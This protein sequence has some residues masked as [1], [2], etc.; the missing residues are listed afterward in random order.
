MRIRELLAAKR[1]EILSAAARFGASNVRII[2]SV[3][4]NEDDE[5][6]DLDLLV[7]L[8][9][10]RSLLD[11]AG[12]ML[13]LQELLG[14]KVDVATVSGLKTRIRGQIMREAVPL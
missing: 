14:R 8:E 7:D 4:R 11:H 12:L 9:K 5:N 6:S 10:G 13:T 2:G 3:A 1:E